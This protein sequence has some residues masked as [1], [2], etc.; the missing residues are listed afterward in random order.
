MGSQEC[1]F[2]LKNPLYCMRNPRKEP[3]RIR[4]LNFAKNRWPPS[5]QRGRRKHDVSQNADSITVYKM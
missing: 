1:C 4:S 3:R 2:R 5:E